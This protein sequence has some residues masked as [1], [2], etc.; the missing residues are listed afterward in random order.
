MRHNL[1]SSGIMNRI[2]EALKEKGIKKRSLASTLV[3][4]KTYE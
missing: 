4:I 1:L 2:K 3:K